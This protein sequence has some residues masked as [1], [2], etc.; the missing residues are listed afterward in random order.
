MNLGLA[1]LYACAHCH[2]ILKRYVKDSEDQALYHRHVHHVYLQ[3]YYCFKCI[4]F[5]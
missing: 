3:L 4:V 1:Y 2:V 5:I